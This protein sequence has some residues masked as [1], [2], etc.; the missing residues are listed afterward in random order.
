MQT[1]QILLLKKEEN[2][3]NFRLTSYIKGTND[4]DVET[5]RTDGMDAFKMH[6][7]PTSFCFNATGRGIN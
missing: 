1:L 5:L 3:L 2:K 4:S 6:A 7:Y